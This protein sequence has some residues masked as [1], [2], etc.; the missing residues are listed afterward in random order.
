MT[1]SPELEPL[2]KLGIPIVEDCAQ[3][4]GAEYRSHRVGSLGELSVF[5]FYATKIITTG[6]GGMILTDDEEHYARLRELRDYDK[7]ALTPTKYNYK[8]TDLQASLGISQLGKLPGFLKRRV[9]I[10]SAYGAAF[11]GRGI[12]L[13]SATPDSKCVFYRYVVMLENSEQICEKA[14]TAGII[15]ERPVFKPLHSNFPAAECPASDRAYSH[16]LSIPLYPSLSQE[17]IDYVTAGLQEI[18]RGSA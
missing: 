14:R 10:A 5:S 18:F 15:C 17:E 2:L 11:S 3:S 7:K 6:E 12:Q 9:Q 4:V 8:M 1:G 16:A 13:P